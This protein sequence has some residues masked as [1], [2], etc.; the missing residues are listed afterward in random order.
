MVN[1]KFVVLR[2]SLSSATY[3]SLYKWYYPILSMWYT[4]ISRWSTSRC[5]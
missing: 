2:Q 3:F 5:L 1:V 4:I